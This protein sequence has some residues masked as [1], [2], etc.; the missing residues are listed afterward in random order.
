MPRTICTIDVIQKAHTSLEILVSEVG[1][2]RFAK[3][4]AV[5]FY[6]A[7][8]PSMLFLRDLLFACHVIEKHL[9]S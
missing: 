5:Q 3:H 6:R 1:I 7:G 8:I 4:A 9:R 2:E